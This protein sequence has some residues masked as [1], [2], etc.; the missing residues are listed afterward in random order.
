MQQ[1]MRKNSEMCT[2]VK[3]RRDKEKKSRGES[4]GRKEDESARR[5]GIDESGGRR[6][7]EGFS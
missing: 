4:E 6:G 5:P 2:T 1:R 7:K 3:D